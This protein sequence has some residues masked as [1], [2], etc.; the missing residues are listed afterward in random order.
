MSGNV[1]LTD[2][3]RRALEQYDPDDSSHRAQKSRTTARAKKA[4]EELTWIAESDEIDNADVFQA[5]AVQ[6]F[7]TELFGEPDEIPPYWEAWN[8]SDEA[9]REYEQEHEYERR[10][11]QSISLIT[12]LYEDRLLAMREP[13]YLEDTEPGAGGLIDPDDPDT[14]DRD[15][16]D[17]PDDRP[18]HDMGAI[19]ECDRCGASPAA[20]VLTDQDDT[21]GWECYNCGHEANE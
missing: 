16:P 5:P 20:I 3:R 12:T 1:F 19:E 4:L 17:T 7:L 15:Q 2:A 6:D 14:D 10:L 8:E 21:K 9:I 18:V 13:E 11:I